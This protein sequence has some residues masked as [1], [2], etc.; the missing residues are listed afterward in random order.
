MLAGLLESHISGYSSIIAQGRRGA[1]TMLEINL[2]TD[3]L[4][5]TYLEQTGKKKVFHT[6]ILFLDQL[7]FTNTFFAL[8]YISDIWI[9]FTCIFV[10]QVLY[11]LG[12]L[13]FN[14]EL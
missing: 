6:G 12:H 7:V 3:N 5:Y 2:K 13:R 9:S 4:I 10:K 8:S 14:N 1:S 11:H